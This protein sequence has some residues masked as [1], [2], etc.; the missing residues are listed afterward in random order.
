MTR[1]NKQTHDAG[2]HFAVAEALMRGYRAVLVNGPGPSGIEVNGRWA[3]VQAAAQGT[4]Q[5]A[6]V[7]AYTSGTFEHA[8][9]VDLTDDRRDIYICP[10]D[11][12]RADVRG[13]H[14]AFLAEHGGQ[15]PRNPDSKHSAIKP[16]QVRRWHNDWSR[17]A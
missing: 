15:R 4:W 1:T 11:A 17:L 7:D 10:G 12:L 2:R 13:R 14:D 3:L 5:I 6:D 9:L 8:V 16:E